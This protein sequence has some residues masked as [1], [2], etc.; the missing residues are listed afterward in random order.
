M[1]NTIQHSR[2]TGLLTVRLLACQCRAFINSPNLNLVIQACR[3][4]WDTRM[5]KALI[6]R[7]TSQTVKSWVPYL[8][9]R[10]T[11]PLYIWVNRFRTVCYF[12]FRAESRISSNVSFDRDASVCLSA[13]RLSDAAH[14][15]AQSE[16]KMSWMTDETADCSCP[17]GGTWLVCS[18]LYRPSSPQ[19]E[20]VDL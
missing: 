10:K 14:S 7:T 12:V 9:K 15:A 20:I 1:A 4:T 19:F 16:S 8:Y 11:P 17:S 5:P 3:M 18:R 2:F 6:V 13:S